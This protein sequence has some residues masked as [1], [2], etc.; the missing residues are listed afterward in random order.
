MF[1][2]ARP[3]E[4]FPTVPGCTSAFGLRSGAWPNTHINDLKNKLIT[5]SRNEYGFIL[6]ATP[7]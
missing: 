3:A 1:G 6:W 5:D 7:T 2:Q 4:Y